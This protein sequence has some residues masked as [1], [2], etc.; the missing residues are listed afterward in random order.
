MERGAINLLQSVARYLVQGLRE[1]DAHKEQNLKSAWKAL[2]YG[3]A[4]EVVSTN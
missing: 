1:L 4:L 3:L 2:Q